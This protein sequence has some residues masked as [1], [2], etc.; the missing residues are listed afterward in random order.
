MWL[1]GCGTVSLDLQVAK[2]GRTRRHL[3]CQA[4]RFIVFYNDEPPDLAKDFL[5]VFNSV[6]ILALHIGGCSSECLD[7]Q[8]GEHLIESSELFKSILVKVRYAYPPSDKKCPSICTDLVACLHM[9][10]FLPRMDA[11]VANSGPVQVQNLGHSEKMRLSKL[12]VIAGLILQQ[13]A[14]EYTTTLNIE[15]T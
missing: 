7:M 5:A 13:Q 1:Q 4:K 10:I 3:P 12:R 15:W 2:E 11:R 8:H 9:S 6:Y 14:I